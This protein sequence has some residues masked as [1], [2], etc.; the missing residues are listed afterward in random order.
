[1]NVSGVMKIVLAKQ[2]KLDAVCE[3]KEWSGERLAGGQ[4]GKADL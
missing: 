2:W 1:M 3:Q 4:R